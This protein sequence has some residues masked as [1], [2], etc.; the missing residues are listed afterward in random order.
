MKLHKKILRLVAQGYSKEALEY[1]VTEH[2]KKQMEKN[3]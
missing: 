1:M 2:V 3:R